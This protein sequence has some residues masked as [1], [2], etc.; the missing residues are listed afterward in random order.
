MGSR[1]QEFFKNASIARLPGHKRPLEKG[2]RRLPL[3]APYSTGSQKFLLS[4]L[5]SMVGKG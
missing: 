2:F 1:Q 3:Y 4:R 5:L